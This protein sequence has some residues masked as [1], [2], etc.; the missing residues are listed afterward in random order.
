MKNRSRSTWQDRLHC[1]TGLIKS[2]RQ[3]PTP[4]TG[5]RLNW[6]DQKNVNLLFSFYENLRICTY[7]LIAFEN[8]ENL[9]KI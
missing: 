5:R 7:L 8:I 6:L 9:C 3:D 4:L 1:S 2:S